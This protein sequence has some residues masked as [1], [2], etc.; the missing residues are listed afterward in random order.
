SALHLSAH[1]RGEERIK[2]IDLLWRPITAHRLRRGVGL[3]IEYVEFVPGS[4]HN[5]PFSYEL[6]VQHDESGWR[7]TGSYTPRDL[8]RL[9]IDNYPLVIRKA[10]YLLK[11]RRAKHQLGNA[12]GRGN[13]RN[14]DHECFHRRCWHGVAPSQLGIRKGAFPFSWRSI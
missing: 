7:I 1:A 10:A 12:C 13:D 5:R 6:G 3:R 9:D 11:L 2:V 4:E 8:E 14:R